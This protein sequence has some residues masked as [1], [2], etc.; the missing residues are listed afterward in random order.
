MRLIQQEHDRSGGELAI[1]THTITS[2]L[3]QDQKSLTA[4]F[5]LLDA[6]NDGIITYGEL[7]QVWTSVYVCVCVCVCER[8][9][10]RQ[11][12]REAPTARVRMTHAC[13]RSHGHRPVQQPQPAWRSCHHIRCQHPTHTRHGTWIPVPTHTI[14]RGPA[15]QAQPA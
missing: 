12:E 13:V 10:E 5:Q 3:Y 2:V 1:N 4:M 14:D 9:R 7:S 15:Q 11:R 8:E 6:D